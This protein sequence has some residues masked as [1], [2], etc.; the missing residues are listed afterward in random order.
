ML[1][2][3][4]NVLLALGL[5]FGA[6]WDLRK[7][8]IPNALSLPLILAGLLL[9]AGEG[10]RAFLASLAAVMVVLGVGFV[11]YAVG[12][13]GGGDAKLIAAIA[14]LRGWAFLT[15][16]L[17]WMAMVGGVVA[18]V[19]LAW[20][21]A[22]IP[23]LRRLAKAGYEIVFL[24]LTPSEPVVEGKGHRIPYAVIIAAGTLAAIVAERLGHEWF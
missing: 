1:S 3:I 23:F 9:A 4:Q 18:L 15:E 13:F 11:L 16:A 2:S 7:G 12:V 6:V 19:L 20:K 17:V 10:W 22:L 8:R 5:T 24:R 14:A 21:R